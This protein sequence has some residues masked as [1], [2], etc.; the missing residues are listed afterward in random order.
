MKLERIGELY[1]LSD[2]L[3]SQAG[4]RLFEE[5][6]AKNQVLQAE[7]VLL[8]AALSESQDLA[9]KERQLA[10]DMLKD[11]GFSLQDLNEP[12]RALPNMANDL[13]WPGR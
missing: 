11:F 5:L 4:Q 3:L 6:V 9:P 2:I 7:A 1:K 10:E 8:G 13:L 12:K